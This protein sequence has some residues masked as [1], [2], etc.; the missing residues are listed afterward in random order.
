[1]IV[2]MLCTSPAFAE[3][4]S[5]VTKVWQKK[6]KKCHGDG[7]AATRIGIKMGAPENLHESTEGQTVEQILESLR[8]GKN[9]MPSFEKKMT[10]DE[11][12]EMASYLHFASKVKKVIE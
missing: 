4:P 2:A 9:K 5:P 8:V 7:V 6:C 10:Q 12:N 1:M 3:E 11:L